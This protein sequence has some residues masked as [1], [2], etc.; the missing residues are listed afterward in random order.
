MTRSLLAYA[1]HVVDA[2]TA[3]AIGLHD[4]D[5]DH[6]QGLQLARALGDGVFAYAPTS[7]RP[8]S[9]RFVEGAATRDG[10]LWFFERDGYVEP[11][12]FGDA[13]R[14]AEA[15]LHDTI[16]R[17]DDADDVPLILVGRGQGGVLALVLTM[18]WPELVDATVA[19][20]ATIPSVPGWSV[21]DTDLGGTVIHLRTTQTAGD[22]DA[23]TKE[24]LRRAGA[25]V[26]LRRIDAASVA[27]DLTSLGSRLLT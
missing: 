21:P 4:F 10:R 25:D 22:E 24:I 19:I 11:S 1:S 3:I 20:D 6:A 7:P 16:E 23:A 18:T 2:P 27:Q 9:P 12:L 8:V 5:E 26:H 13:L 15:F 17:H 14:Q